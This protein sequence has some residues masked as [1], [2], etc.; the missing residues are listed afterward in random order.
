MKKLIKITKKFLIREYVKNQKTMQ[1]IADM[2]GCSTKPVRDALKRYNIKTNS[3]YRSKWDKILTK[4]FLIKKY[5]KNRKSPT[6]IA[7][8][9]G[10]SNVTVITYLRKFNIPIRTQS[11]S[12]KGNIPWNKGIAKKHYCKEPKC[13]NEVSD[14][15]SKRCRKCQNKFRKGKNHPMYGKKNPNLSK[16][17]KGRTPWNKGT[18]KKNKCIDCGKETKLYT[19]DR[20]ND[21]W[22][23]WIKNPENNAGFIDG[24]CSK[25]YY[26]KEKKCNNEITYYT[27]KYGDKRCE[28]CYHKFNRGKNHHSYIE[29]LDREY[30]AE[31]DSHLKEQIRFRDGYKCQECGCSQLENAKQLDV[32]HIDYNKKNCKYNNLI[33]LCKSCHPKTNYNRKHWKQHFQTKVKV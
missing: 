19:A 22:K 9:V 26:C 24:R 6:E 3:N 27:W 31:F 15:R 8:K 33:S 16:V 30:G 5:S 12:M 11:E 20:C 4:K 25:K 28:D 23:I 32:H 1:Q 18:A 7:N 13:K 14:S 2:L 21:C 29:G 17:M 10:C